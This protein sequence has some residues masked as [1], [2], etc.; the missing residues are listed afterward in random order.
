MSPADRVLEM[1]RYCL[2]KDGEPT[3]AA[4]KVESVVGRFGFHPERLAETRTE[5]AELIRE[6]VP[7]EFLKGGGE[8]YSFLQLCMDR[9]GQQWAEH[10]TLDA[11]IALALATELGGFCL[12]RDF[13]GAFPGGMPY[14]WFDV[15]D[16]AERQPS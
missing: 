6:V 15:C 5:L 7:D 13:W 11:L 9:Q 3:D 16:R 8:G 12:P 4:V 2:F 10:P 1:M 14:V